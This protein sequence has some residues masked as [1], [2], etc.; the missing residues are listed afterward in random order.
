MAEVKIESI[1]EKHEYDIKNALEAAL[2]DVLPNTTIDKNQLY[3]AFYKA[4]GRKL[5]TWIT[6]DDR[7][8]T[9]R[10]RHCR[11]KT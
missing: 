11:E 9:V 5:S 8:V 10:C 7:D 4:V 3:K 1:I 6:V 2:K